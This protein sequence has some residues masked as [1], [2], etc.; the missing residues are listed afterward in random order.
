MMLKIPQQVDLMGREAWNPH[1]PPSGLTVY[2]TTPPPPFVLIPRVPER[3]APS[4]PD[5]HVKRQGSAT[6]WLGP[7]E[8]DFTL[9]SCFSPSIS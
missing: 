2:Q 5:A 8:G 3:R 1:H 6:H 7:Y 9:S 4:Y